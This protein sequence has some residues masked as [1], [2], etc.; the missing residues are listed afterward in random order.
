MLLDQETNSCC[1][2]YYAAKYDGN[3]H[4]PNEEMSLSLAVVGRGI[5]TINVRLQIDM[6]FY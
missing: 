6:H 2:K 3:N 5:R 4:A 1:H